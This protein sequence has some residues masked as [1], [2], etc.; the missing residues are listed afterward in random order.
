VYVRNLSLYS[1]V[2]KGCRLLRGYSG[3]GGDW[4][5]KEGAEV[6]GEM[7]KQFA[8]EGQVGVV[9]SWRRGCATMWRVERGGLGCWCGDA[10][11]A[12]SKLLT[13]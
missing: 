5:C 8:V 11:D 6:N 12:C 13:D 4:R 10:F 1:G 2:I 9:L 3:G 7:T